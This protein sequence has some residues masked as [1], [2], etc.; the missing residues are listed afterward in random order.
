MKWFPFVIL[1]VLSGA[2]T[3]ACRSATPDPF[4]AE[5]VSKY[6]SEAAPEVRLDTL[7]KHLTIH[8]RA[9]DI[10]TF[11]EPD[12]DRRALD[13]A[14]FALNHYPNS[15]DLDSIT[16]RFIAAAQGSFLAARARHYARADVPP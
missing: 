9:P 11:S 12:V 15:S 4:I 10:A 5:L 7:H 3:V 13:V 2:S 14:R 16:V 8:F 6:G 1:L